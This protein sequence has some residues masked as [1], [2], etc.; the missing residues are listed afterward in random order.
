MPAWYSFA[1]VEGGFPSNQFL[2]V[3]HHCL[4][5][6]GA[7]RVERGL[8]AGEPS[9]HGN[10]GGTRVRA[11]KIIGEHLYLSAAVS[12]TQLCLQWQREANK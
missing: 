6:E 12:G 10:V 5:N 7:A 2:L 11:M 8:F 4:A 9:T 3:L 1:V